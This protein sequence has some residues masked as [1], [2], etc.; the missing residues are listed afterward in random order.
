LPFAVIAVSIVV[1]SVVAIESDPLGGIAAALIM[2]AALALI[3]AVY[4]GD[5]LIQSFR[6]ARKNSSPQG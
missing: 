5:A 6:R 4:L 2:F 3:I 1:A